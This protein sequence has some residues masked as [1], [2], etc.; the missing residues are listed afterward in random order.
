MTEQVMLDA[1]KEPVSFDDD[2]EKPSKTT[3]VMEVGS[4]A[5]RVTLD[6]IGIT[7][8]GRDFGAIKNPK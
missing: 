4:W 3:A 6:I 2:V 7:G 1:V 8:L 5:S